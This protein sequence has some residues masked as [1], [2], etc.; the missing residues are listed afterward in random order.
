MFSLSQVHIDSG[1]CVYIYINIYI[2]IYNDKSGS[3][4]PY[5]NVLNANLKINL[6]STHPR[7]V[8]VNLLDC[9]IMGSELEGC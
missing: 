3:S 2:Y 6:R 8:A 9:I 1:V 5:R 7:D 4:L